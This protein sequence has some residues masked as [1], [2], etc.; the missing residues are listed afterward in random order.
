VGKGCLKGCL[1]AIPYWL[2]R[3]IASIA[4]FILSLFGKREPPSLFRTIVVCIVIG[5]VVVMVFQVW[6]VTS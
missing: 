5:L 1:L 2:H 3:I 4:G 6:R